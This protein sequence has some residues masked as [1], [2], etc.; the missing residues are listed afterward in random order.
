MKTHPWRRG[1]KTPPSYG[2]QEI[3]SILALIGYH[4]YRL[5][6]SQSQMS[7]LLNT[8]FKKQAIGSLNTEQ[9]KSFLSQIEKAQSIEE[10]SCLDG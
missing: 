5:N 8:R 2:E 1:F 7:E 9:L 4:R 6:I 10:L 3:H